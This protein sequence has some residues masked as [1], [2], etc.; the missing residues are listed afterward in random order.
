[1]K[2]I[3]LAIVGPSGSGK[4]SLAEMLKQ[5]LNIPVIV[6]Y[7]TRP[8][9]AGE[10]DGVEHYF[11]EESIMPPRDK[12][13]AYTK[14]GGFHYWSQ[15]NQIPPSGPCSYVIDEKGLIKL[16]E[17]YDDMYDIIP[18]LIKRDISKL[19]QEVDSDRLKRDKHRIIIEDAGYEAIIDNNGTLEEFYKIALSTIK[20]LL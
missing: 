9:R 8:M 19:K 17:E 18:I 10:K 15:H 2:P 3:I 1:M 13:L 14:F 20:K 5:K 12:M 6:S 16:M 4:T 7:T 11:V